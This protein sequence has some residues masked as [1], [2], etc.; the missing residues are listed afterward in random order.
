MWLLIILYNFYNNMSFITPIRSIKRMEVLN[1]FTL[2]LFLDSPVDAF[3]VF[4][5]ILILV[6]WLVKYSRDLEILHDSSVE[7]TCVKGLS[8]GG[9]FY[10]IWKLETFLSNKFITSLLVVKKDPP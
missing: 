4:V 8:F 1:V 3:S 5:G 2:I 9:L 6:T 7:Q 10:K